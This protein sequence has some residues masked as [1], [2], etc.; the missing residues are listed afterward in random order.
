MPSPSGTDRPVAVS[1]VV[2]V[3]GDVEPL[4]RLVEA[5]ARQSHPVDAT[6]VILVDNGAVGDLCRAAGR[7]PRTRVVREEQPGSYAAR[8]RGLLHARGE[9]IAF[10]DADCRPHPDWLAAGLAALGAD[11]RVGLVAGH[12]E[13]VCA[14]PER[15]AWAELYGLVGFPQEQWARERHWAAT[16]NAFTR[17]TVIESVGPFDPRLKS[18]GDREWGA[19]VHAAGWRVVF[20]PEARVEHPVRRSLGAVLAREA[21][22]AGGAHDLTPPGRRWRALAGSGRLALRQARALRASPRLS[23]RQHIAALPLVALVA[24]VNFGEKLRLLLGGTSRRY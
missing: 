6:E 7:H 12:V 9:A 17:R 11:P 21:R 4:H 1:V 24:A 5:L 14:D 13:P 8:N 23:S 16:A 18:M 19:R 15:P 3:H 22:L 10:T 20:A 2:P